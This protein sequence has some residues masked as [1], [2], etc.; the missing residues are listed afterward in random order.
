MIEW[1]MQ[2]PSQKN[3]ANLHGTTAH[4]RLAKI[5]LRT[6]FASQ[7]SLLEYKFLQK[8]EEFN[9]KIT[10]KDNLLTEIIGH[11]IFYIASVIS[12]PAPMVTKKPS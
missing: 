1:I 2:Q 11:M 10:Q 5:S 3:Y 7:T 8:T 9:R 6:S 12:L 4:Y